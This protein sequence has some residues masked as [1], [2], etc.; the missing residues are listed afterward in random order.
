M[1]TL[2]AHPAGLTF[3]NEMISRDE[4]LHTDF[5]CHLYELLQCRW[6]PQQPPDRNS[7]QPHWLSASCCTSS[8]ICRARLREDE[9]LIFNCCS[10]RPNHGGYRVTLLHL[11]APRYLHSACMPAGGG[12][13]TP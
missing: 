10:I 7:F 2:A 4:G 11:S 12:E 8:A 5:A 1:A 13:D 3:S 9:H 6:A